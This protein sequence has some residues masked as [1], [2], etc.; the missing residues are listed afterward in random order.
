MTLVAGPRPALFPASRTCSSIRGHRGFIRLPSLPSLPAAEKRHADSRLLPYSP[1]QLFDIV[2]NVDDYK[3]FLP[4]TLASRVLTKP[5]ARPDGGST[6]LAE[7]TVGF[8]ALRESYIS[9][10][11]SYPPHRVIATAAD[12]T[13]FRTMKTTWTFAPTTAGNGKMTKVGFEI[14]FAFNNPVHAAAAGAFF[15]KVSEEVMRAF[16][17][18]C[19][20]VYGN[21]G[22]G[23]SGR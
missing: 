14:A 9:Q 1:A 12:S 17:R 4:L 3:T 18:R 7:L 19:R 8:G 16:E 23:E 13:L 6:V 15:D 11:T 2:R 21:D 22:Q 10:V 5:R 20:E